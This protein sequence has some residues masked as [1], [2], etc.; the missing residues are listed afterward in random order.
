MTGDELLSGLLEL[1]NGVSLSMDKCVNIATDGTSSMN[2]VK[3]GMEYPSNIKYCLPIIK[4]NTLK[5]FFISTKTTKLL[6]FSF[7]TS[8]HFN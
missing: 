1:C 3:K 7:F 5:D 8:F 6:L 2:G 4:H